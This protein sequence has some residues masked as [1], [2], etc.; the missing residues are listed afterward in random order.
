VKL[1]QVLTFAAMAVAFAFSLD[2]FRR[3]VGFA[4]PWFGLL[5][6]L[7]VLG[8]ANAARPFVF[9]RVP[10]SLRRIRP[11]ELQA[12]WH[13]ALRVPAFGALLRRSPLRYLNPAV[14]LERHA[15]DYR[16]VCE[17]VE[18]AEAAHLWAGLVLVPFMVYTCA[19]E[20]WGALAGFVVVQIVGNLY[21]IL[22]LRLVRGRLQRVLGRTRTRR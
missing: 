13:R 12:L 1:R 19:D 18:A 17:D 6:M 4:S 11:W 10:R 5:L 22:H 15:R 2:Q 16:A 21:P 20:R 14:Y 8:L 9:L 3:F 7:C